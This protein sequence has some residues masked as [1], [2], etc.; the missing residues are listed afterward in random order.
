MEAEHSFDYGSLWDELLSRSLLVPFQDMRGRGLIT[1]LKNVLDHHVG[2]LTQTHH[3]SSGRGGFDDAWRAY[4]SELALEEILYGHPLS[5]QDHH[6]TKILGTSASASKSITRVRG[7]PGLARHNSATA[8]V[9]PLPLH[10]WTKDSRNAIHIKRIFCLVDSLGAAPSVVGIQLWSVLM[11]DLYREADVGGHLA[12]LKKE[13]I[14]SFRKVVSASRPETLIEL[15]DTKK[16]FPFPMVFDKAKELV[17][18][19][20]RN[21]AEYMKLG[22]QELQLRW[23]PHIRYW[24]A[25]HP[26]VSWDQ[27]SMVQFYEKDK[28]IHATTR[29]AIMQK[30][31]LT[32][33]ERRG[34]VFYSKLQHYQ[35]VELPWLH[36]CMVRATGAIKK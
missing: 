26:S 14:P 8:E 20:G 16:A 21:V 3:S 7:F 33:I 32:E 12:E 30:H 22:Q 36:K 11:A 24:Q 10:N 4:Q 9:S 17:W 15:L 27:K 28:L 23:L 34:L 18:A 25:R 6:M 31:V 2:V 19:R 29:V 35:E 1:I 13:N 5:P